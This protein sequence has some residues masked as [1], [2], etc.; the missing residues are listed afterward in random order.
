MTVPIPPFPV[1]PSY[2]I[3]GLV[4]ASDRTLVYRG[5]REVDQ[6]PVVLKLLRQQPPSLDDD[7]RL[8]NHYRITCNLNLV[9]VRPPLG[10]EPYGQS[11]VLIT[12]DDG[13]CSLADFLEQSDPRRL[14][15]SQ[16]LPIAIQLSTVLA[17][18]H[19]HRI[20]HKDIK[21]S[22]ILIQPETRQITLIDFGLASQLPQETQTLQAPGLLEGTL[23]YL[24]PEQTGR[25]NRGIDYRSDFYALGVTFYELLTGQLPFQ[26]NDPLELVYCHLAQE[27][28]LPHQQMP[29]ASIPEVLSQIVLK[30]MA[31]NA[32]DRYQSALGLKADLE[33]CLKQANEAGHLSDFRLGQIDALSQFNI[34]QKLY[35][36]ETPVNTL[37]EAFERVSQGSFELVLIRGYSGVGKTALVNEI[38]RQLTRHRGYFTAGKFDQF[39]RDIPL[40]ASIQLFRSL[41]R[42]LLTEPEDQLA[43]WRTRMLAVLGANAQLMIE[44]IPEL[45]LII[46]QQPAVPALGAVETANRLTLVFTK[47]AQ[48]FQSPQHPFVVFMDDLQ[49][50]DLASLQALQSVMSDPTNAHRLII[51]AY[52]DNEVGP[53]HPLMRTIE[54]IRAAGCLITEINLEPLSLKHV[55]QWVAETLHRSTQSVEPLAQLLFDKTAGNP[56]FLTQLLKSLYEDGL[57]WFDP[58]PSGQQGWQWHLDQIQQC[59][60]TDN[61]VD[62]M[63]GKI[64]RLSEPTQQVLQLAACIGN[65][66][67]FQ[68]L[69]TVSQQ[70]LVETAQELW[71]AIQTGLI[72]PSDERYRFPQLLN[73][74]EMSTL[75]TEYT[76]HYRFVHD[77]IQQA[78]NFLIPEAQ[79]QAVHLQIGRLL[80]QCIPVAE[81]EER[82]FEIV[83]HYNEGIVLIASQIE[84]NE[85]AQFNL[86]AAHKAKSAAAYETAQQYCGCGHRLLGEDSW[87]T[88]YDL[89]LALTELS[90]EVAYLIGD[91]EQMEQ[92]ASILIRKAKTLLERI[93]VHEIKTQAYTAQSQQLKI[94]RMT[95]R[96]LDELSIHLPEHPDADD[97]SHRLAEIQNLL[98]D[99]GISSLIDLPVMTDAIMLAAMRLLASLIG[100]TFVVQPALLPLIVCQQVELSLHYGNTDLS[101][102]AYAIYGLILCGILSEYEFGYQFGQLALAI[103][104]KFQADQIQARTLHVVYTHISH[105]QIHLQKTLEPLQTAC[106]T[107]LDTGDLEYAGYAATHYCKHSY[108]SGRPLNEI[109]TKLSAYIQTFTSFKQYREVQHLQMQR[110]MIVNL[111]NN[112]TN[113][114]SFLDCTD[115]LIRREQFIHANDRYGLFSL[116]FNQLQYN[117]LFQNFYQAVEAAD[118]AETYLDGV[119][120]MAVIPIF[121]FY[122]SLSRLAVCS[123]SVASVHTGEPTAAQLPSPDLLAKV[124]CQQEKMLQWVTQGPMNHQHKYDLVEAERHR[125]SGNN[126][127]AINLYDRA[128]AGAQENSYLQEA[129]LANELAAKFYLDWGKPKVAAGYLQEAY[130]YYAHWGAGAKLVDLETRYPGL[131]TPLIQLSQPALQAGYSTSIP[132]DQPTTPQSSSNDSSN[133]LDL[134]TILKASQAISQE[135]QLEQLLSTLMQIVMENAGAQTGTLILKMGARWQIAAYCPNAQS[136]QLQSL[137]IEDSLDLPL[138]LLHYVQRTQETVVIDDVAD[139]HPFLADSYWS[140]QVSKSVLCV[141]ILNQG[142]LLGLLHLENQLTAGAFTTDRQEVIQLIAAQA[143]ISIEN[144]QLYSTLE[145]KVE[146]RTQ[147]LSQALTHLQTTQQELI[148]SEK[149]AA[150][151]QLTAS[152]AHEINTPL[153]VIRAASSNIMAAFDVTLQRLPVLWSQLSEQQMAEFLALIQTAVQQKQSFSTQAERQQRRQWQTQLEAQGIAHAARLATQLTLLRL[154]DISPFRTLLSDHHAVEILQTAVEV[155]SQYQHASSIHQEVDRAAKIVFALKTYSYQNSTGER[156]WVDIT[157]GIEIALT[158]YQNRLKQGIEVIRHYDPS[159]P[160]LLCNP[161]ELIQVWVNLIDNAIY[162]IGRQGQLKIDVTQTGDQIVVEVTDSGSGISPEQ[163]SRIFEPFFTTK[164]RGEGSGLGLD[165]VRQIVEKHGGK[166][167]VQSQP[168]RTTL[169]VMFPL[170]STMSEVER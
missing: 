72:L 6:Q 84:R 155:V 86:L 98:T 96:F 115:D 61:V 170:S 114:S 37:L 14:F 82:I 112:H 165:I 110:Q 127:E 49:W 150:L 147:E 8:R 30:L 120:G 20:I 65:P 38:L 77:R 52:R 78:A 154:Q 125:I 94:I 157:E 19:S 163:Q 118:L 32:E 151:G 41:V 106:Q 105:W 100:P 2:R 81:R 152:V 66:F 167:Q 103:V 23:A 55:K 133:L 59:D 15:W 162:A 75:L 121:Y 9:G 160:Q 46:G 63:I 141:P 161:D 95:L 39:Q 93:R 89:T 108:F 91:F 146:E 168:G 130:S 1:I 92:W 85:L 87:Q 90:A 79:K 54:A 48:V 107:G 76:I 71:E 137:P 159:V 36:R 158:L 57:I 83:N 13:S 111:I 119:T 18:L 113:S 144:S 64:I 169:T 56:F 166:I 132:T 43:Y 42:Q 45:E 67:D 11:F 3:T 53:T 164:P 109:E 99:R 101:A 40:A 68:T 27:P 4:H 153:G 25:M 135:I 80:L 104:E 143:A 5:I 7:L 21:P 12:H 29:D 50:A 124:A 74:D 47:F 34:P 33:R 123:H 58:A 31:K 139:P 142:Q 156:S 102:F 28:V 140:R 128:V 138:S 62:L 122:D 129:A 88:D 60:V 24:S 51:I 97:V 17:G 44:I 145:Q 131:L 148:Q 26:S 16:F 117:Y 134:A 10:F 126:A 136:C 69:A 70:S 35:G 149:M 73:T 116:F 22:N